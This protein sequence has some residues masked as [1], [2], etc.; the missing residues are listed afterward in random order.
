M[1]SYIDAY[2]ELVAGLLDVSGGDSEFE[3]RE[4]IR[5]I[6]GKAKPDSLNQREY[7]LCRDMVRRRIGGEPLQY[8]FGHWEFYGREFFVGKG[9]LIPR[10]ETEILCERAIKRLKGKNGKI[11]DLCAGTGCIGIT[12]SL[13]SGMCC[14]AVEKSEQAYG[15]LLKNASSL[16]ADKVN[17]IC[18]DIFDKAVISSFEDNSLAAILS[19]PPYIT[20]E[21]MKGLQREVLQEP[22]MALCG[23]EDGLDFYRG[24]IGHY[25]DKLKRSGFFLFEIGDTQGA[26]VKSIAAGFGF[27]A[28]II[29]DY[30]GLDRMAFVTKPL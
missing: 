2:R 12:V 5:E 9:V 17:T 18:G 25:K 22:F 6:C 23:G 1:V 24:I 14:T 26:A 30:S 11:A 10:P 15:Y 28:D 13:E 29:R 19:N 16:H 7:E 21:E 4:I 3:A 8:I 20:S 27:N